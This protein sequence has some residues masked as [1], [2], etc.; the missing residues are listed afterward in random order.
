[1]MTY[2]RHLPE[3]QSWNA[4]GKL[5]HR[6]PQ[7]RLQRSAGQNS[8]RDTVPDTSSDRSGSECNSKMGLLHGTHLSLPLRSMV[9]R[10]TPCLQ[11]HHAGA[12]RTTQGAAGRRGS[13]ELTPALNSTPTSPLAWQPAPG[14]A[15][16]FQAGAEAAGVGSSSQGCRGGCSGWCGCPGERGR[17]RFPAG[18]LKLQRGACGERSTRGRAC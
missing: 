4:A 15:Q 12:K 13:L 18:L 17:C 3:A 9:Q 6:R 5:D 2:P 11:R 14:A 16:G 10:V 7:A 1:M 8:S